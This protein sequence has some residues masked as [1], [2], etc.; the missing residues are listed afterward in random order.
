VRAQ[1]GSKVEN[2]TED[3]RVVFGQGE[4][5]L[6]SLVF[7]LIAGGA[8]S[9]QQY[10]VPWWHQQYGWS[11]GKAAWILG[12]AYFTVPFA[13]LRA[14]KLVQLLG[15]KQVLVWGAVVNLAFTVGAFTLQQYW[16]LMLVTISWA[17]MASMHWAASSSLVTGTV[18]GHLRGAAAGFFFASQFGGMAAGMYGFG[19][20]LQHSGDEAARSLMCL[21]VGA[22]VLVALLVP[23][24]VLSPRSVELKAVLASLR[25]PNIK[26]A[27]LALFG[28][29]LGLGAMW[30]AFSTL[31]AARFGLA[32]MRN[33]A[34]GFYVVRILVSL[35][36][37]RLSDLHGRERML[38][39]SFLVAA[40]G[41]VA[42]AFLTTPFTLVMAATALGLCSAF[43]NV[44]AT[45]LAGD[46]FGPEQKVQAMSALYSF[47]D[48]AVFLSIIL[49]PYLR[50]LSG[51]FTV[52]FLVLASLYLAT[53]ALAGK[54]AG[55]PAKDV[56]S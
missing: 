5:L 53:G 19:F 23:A 32:L 52:P 55:K 36:G 41:L 45:A 35:L 43:S 12:A 27:A 11:L 28:G 7:F 50:T 2:R 1:P 4:L 6:L 33:L 40:I 10:L 54:F 31:I 29:A 44:T 18:P 15:V 3:W 46:V 47:A 42:A 49:G 25:L 38:Q 20:V 48:L 26:I 51:G 56:A 17:M 21:A 8:Y 37:G 22:A 16:L 30:G 24:D 13:R 9:I 14:A 39:V 34:L